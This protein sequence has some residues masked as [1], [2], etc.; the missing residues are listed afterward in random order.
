MAAVSAGENLSD[1]KEQ[2]EE[3]PSK[4][5][6]L[7]IYKLRDQRNDRVTLRTRQQTN[8]QEKA[9]PVKKDRRRKV[10]D[11]RTNEDSNTKFSFH[12]SPKVNK[13]KKIVPSMHPQPSAQ[14][15]S[16]MPPLQSVMAHNTTR[17]VFDVMV[18]MV[19]E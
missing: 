3:P 9:F 5:P 1:C 13:C 17:G 8:D 6:S 10:S 16:D 15:A 2:G 12:S 14:A 18:T 19:Y 11:T 7:V 4:K